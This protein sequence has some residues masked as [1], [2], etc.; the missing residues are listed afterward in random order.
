MPSALSPNATFSALR[1]LSSFSEQLG[2]ADAGGGVD[3]PILGSI[4]EL[5]ETGI[6]LFPT[7]PPPVPP[8][9]P[10]SPLPPF[11][12]FPPFS[13]GTRFAPSTES[14]ARQLSSSQPASS[15]SSDATQ[16]ASLDEASMSKLNATEMRQVIVN[17][18][19]FRFKQLAEQEAPTIIKQVRPRPP[20]I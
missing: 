5:L 16:E 1:T 12:A 6:V 19:R 8:L 11:P 9:P 10:P 14:V 3:F 13:P 15:S 20:S 4:Q 7:P 17:L 18:A 2:D